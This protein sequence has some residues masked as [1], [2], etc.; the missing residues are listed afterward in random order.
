MARAGATLPPVEEVFDSKRPEYTWQMDL[1][2][3]AL[4]AGTAEAECGADEARSQFDSWKT[5]LDEG[6]F[7]HPKLFYDEGPG[8]FRFSDG[9]FA[10]ARPRE[11]SGAQEGR[12]L[13]R[14]GDVSSRTAPARRRGCVVRVVQGPTEGRL[15]GRR[16]ITDNPGARDGVRGR[17]H[18]PG[19]GGLRP[20]TAVPRAGKADRRA[21]RNFVRGG[22]GLRR[23]GGVAVRGDNHPGQ[24]H[25]SLRSR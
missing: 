17:S 12:L 21:D 18:R 25:V 7:D 1:P 23:V 20:L 4:K 9:A 19:R 22:G 3:W 15:R 13:P 16:H 2:E 6:L 10:L 14:V 8:F 5:L 24:C 11:L